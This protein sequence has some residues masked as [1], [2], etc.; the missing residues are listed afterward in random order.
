MSRIVVATA[1]G[2]PEVLRVIKLICGA[3]AQ[4]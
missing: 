1:F 3:D 2:G 4:T